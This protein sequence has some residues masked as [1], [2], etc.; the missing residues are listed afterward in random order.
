MDPNKIFKSA[1]ESQNSDNHVK[2]EKLYKK[3]LKMNPEIDAKKTITY[4]LGLVYM[5]MYNYKD[6]IKYFNISDRI[7]SSVETNWNKSISYFNLLEWDKAV[8][9]FSN[10]YKSTSNN[11]TSVS[12][13]NFPIEQINDANLSVGKNLLVM[14]EQGLGDELLF[15]T[16]LIK[17]DKIVKSATVQVSESM[18]DLLNTIYKFDNIE[19]VCF[20][21]ISLEDVEK[22]DMFIGLGDVFMSLYNLGD[23][24][25]DF[26]SNDI[27]N[28]K[29]GVCWMTNRKSPNTNK[30][31]IN[32]SI[33]KK[34][35]YDMVSLQYGNGIDLG[36][37]NFNPKNCLETWEKM[38]DL[39]VVVTV[40]TLVAHMAGL[41]GIPTLLVINEHLDWRW[42]YRDNDDNRYSMFYPN[43]EIISIND[44]INS[45]IEEL[46]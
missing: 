33:F 20:E 40:D 7:E 4:N 37:D 24:V 31:S 6:A 32:P 45:I 38:D 28:G 2:A 18:I 9:L 5:S 3:L 46:I 23:S 25:T 35:N 44:D 36:L 15:T 42:K 30:R 11:I 8:N 16:Q 39:S 21:S 19:L 14:N 41:K 13:P 34:I 27:S 22:Y 10:R 17:L 29:V 12:F 1:F 26:K 43:I